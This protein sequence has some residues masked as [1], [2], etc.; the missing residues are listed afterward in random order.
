MIKFLVT[1]VLMEYRSKRL[2]ASLRRGHRYL[3]STVVTRFKILGVTNDIHHLMIT[4]AVHLVFMLTFMDYDPP[5]FRK[6]R[7]RNYDG[8]RF[9]FLNATG[10]FI[11]RDTG[12]FWNVARRCK[13]ASE[14]GS[15]SSSKETYNC[16][17]W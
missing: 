10:L 13:P 5:T 9:I 11:E 1:I 4:F 14:C 6:I 2:G 3:E 17:S 12:E 7:P 8:G 16:S 15:Y